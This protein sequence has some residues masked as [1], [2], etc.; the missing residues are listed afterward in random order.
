M[1]NKL[2]R[3]GHHREEDSGPDTAIEIIQNKIPRKEMEIHQCT[4][5]SEITSRE[6]GERGRKGAGPV[7]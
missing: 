7:W 6:R 5:S 4:V 3:T 1:K 2:D